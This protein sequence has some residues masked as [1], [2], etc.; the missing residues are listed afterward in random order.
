MR[1]V[2]LE[3]KIMSILLS[4]NKDE[5]IQLNNIESMSQIHKRLVNTYGSTI[6]SIF[7]IKI[8]S[9]YAAIHSM[10]TFDTQTKFID[11]DSLFYD[12]YD[13]K[14][15]NYIQS[16]E[17]SMQLLSSYLDNTFDSFN[18]YF[19]VIFKLENSYNNI[20]ITTIKYLHDVLIDIQ[21]YYKQTYTLL[22]TIYT[23]I[24]IEQNDILIINPELT[25][26]IL[27][28]LLDECRTIICMF[29]TNFDVFKLK[30]S[31]QYELL[32][33]NILFDVTKL[34][35]KNLNASLYDA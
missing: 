35:I 6:N 23:T 12:I 19:N 31:K 32:K 8:I 29:Y 9:I 10:I 16:S 30:V 17:T 34:R 15:C 5:L 13:V 26:E 7:Y 14:M 11:L 24:F 33:K 21:T 27:N 1:I 4:F 3:S 22:K 28:A 20:N 25:E 2:N 18:T